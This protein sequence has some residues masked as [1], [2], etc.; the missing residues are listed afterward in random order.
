MCK[1]TGAGDSLAVL[2][3]LDVTGGENALNACVALARLGDQV[4]VLIHVELTLEQLGG[5]VVSDGVEE[6]LCLDGLLLLGD[7]VAHDK[8]RHEAAL[9]V[10]ALD[11][12]CARV[13]QD[14]DLGVCSEPPGVGARRP[15]L[16][17]ADQDS[18]LLRLLGQVQRLLDSRVTAANDDQG[19]VAEHGQTAVADSACRNT[20]TPVF[21]LARQVET[22]CLG[23][24]RNDDRVGGVLLLL[25][26]LVV[27]H[28]VQPV[29]EGAGFEV[30][31]CDGL[32]DDLSAAG[33]GLCTHLV[34]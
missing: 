7:V 19:L 25:N 26:L 14:F 24:S 21:L 33:F 3:V 16:V 6:T 17:T 2:L 11:L 9:L 28:G 5:G 15:Q 31:L 18:D 12:G 29:L 34:L 1:L 8:M 23:T 22:A 13:E 20:V 30:D 4:T 10:L 32:G 27:T